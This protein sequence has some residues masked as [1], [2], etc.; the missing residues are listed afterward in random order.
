LYPQVF[1]QKPKE[2]CL[3][4]DILSQLGV[5]NIHF[6]VETAELFLTLMEKET[7]AT[8]LQSIA[9]G[10][11]HIDLEG[12]ESLQSRICDKLA[13]L[14]HHHDMDVR[15]GVTMGLAGHNNPIAITTLI[16]MMEDSDEEV[17]NWATFAIG[18]QIDDDNDTIRTA[19]KKRLNEEN[20]EIRGEALVG[21]AQRHD[22]DCLSYV[23]H[24]FEQDEISCLLF[25]AI[26]EL[27]ERPIALY[28]KL[29]QLKSIADGN[30]VGQNDEHV[31]FDDY[32]YQRLLETIEI[33]KPSP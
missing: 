18:Q 19:L 2:R 10:F 23:F 21:L 5:N 20:S 14:K 12:N 27:K 6:P 32:W 22:K 33:C 24:E 25:D 1:L 11:S 15:Q 17:R 7:E 28:D 8:V 13:L 31:K 29:L 30:S 9:V 16:E 4:V 26:N 3:G